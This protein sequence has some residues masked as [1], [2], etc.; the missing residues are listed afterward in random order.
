MRGM[1][2]KAQ[3]HAAARTAVGAGLRQGGPTR[4][5]VRGV[6]TF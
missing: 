2:H 5:N 6:K 3:L 1:E 4:R